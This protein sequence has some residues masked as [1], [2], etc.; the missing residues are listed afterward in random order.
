MTRIEL[1]TEIKNK[2][3]KLFTNV[4]H[5]KTITDTSITD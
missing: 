3:Q 2:N 1:I 5:Y 4:L